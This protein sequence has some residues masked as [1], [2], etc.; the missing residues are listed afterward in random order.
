MSARD[1]HPW[2]DISVFLSA[3]LSHAWLVPSVFTTHTRYVF[4]YLAV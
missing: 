2:G 3:S 4:L 1:V